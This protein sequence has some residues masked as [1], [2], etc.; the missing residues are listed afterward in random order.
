MPSG[1]AL[2]PEFWSLEE[3]TSYRTTTGT[4]MDAQRQQNPTSEE[5]ALVKRDCGD[6]GTVIVLRRVNL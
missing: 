4:Q 6:D 3:L 2:W 1:K 5:G